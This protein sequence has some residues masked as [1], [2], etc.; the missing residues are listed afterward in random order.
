M[1][2]SKPWSPFAG[3]IYGV[4]RI[5]EREFR[6]IGQTTG[7]G[8]RRR[9]QHFK[10]ARRGKKTA[11]YDWLR[12]LA[13]PEDVYFQTLELVVGGAEQLDTRECEWIAKLR[14]EG[15]RLLNHTEGGAGVRGYEWTEEQRRAAGDRAQGREG[16][17]RP[18]RDNPM[19]GRTH[20]E[21]QK[22][23]WSSLRKG[24]NSGSANPNFGKFGP[25][26]P[27][28]GHQVSAETRRLLSAQKQGERNPNYGK[29]AGDETRAKMSAVRRG[30]PMP[31]SARSAH[32]RHHT[33]KS[34]F[35]D[36]CRHCLDD[37][38]NQ[39]IRGSE[40]Q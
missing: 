32:T 31:S 29:T 12:K 26:H 7:T 3:L 25:E 35:K 8:S 6:Y 24:S 11:F 13:S 39:T 20:S 5:G 28:F 14:R 33:N 30:R 40:E 16:I 17:S 9:M 2:D 21:E 1:E 19:W 27:E 18:G 4:R 36:S 34:V 15:H 10:S 38:Q 23:R 22:A 37:R